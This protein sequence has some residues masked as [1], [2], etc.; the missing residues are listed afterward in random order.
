MGIAKSPPKPTVLP[1]RCQLHATAIRESTPAGATAE[2]SAWETR[3]S[4]LLRFPRQIQQQAFHL[5]A[6]G[7]SAAPLEVGV[8]LQQ[9]AEDLF[10]FGAA[11]TSQIAAGGIHISRKDTALLEGR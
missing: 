8:R 11:D 7:E 10:R 1:S 4:G 3:G 2:P 6:V 5:Q 9:T